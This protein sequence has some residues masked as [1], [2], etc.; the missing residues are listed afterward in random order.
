MF[1]LENNNEKIGKYLEHL[2]THQYP[3]R[4]AF[5]RA[6]ITATG[7]QPTNETLNNMSNR[8][9]QI[10]KGNKSIQ[11]YD[12]P[13]FTELL[14]IS[15]EQILS[16]GECSAPIASRITNY[17]IA[18]SKDPEAWEAYIHRSDKLILNS[19]EY[20]KTVLDYALDFGNYDFI[21]FLMDNQYIW[22]DS[23][24]DQD[25]IQT[26]GAG[27][28]IE[29]RHISS[30]DYGLEGKLRTEDE[31]RINL[32]TLAVDHEDIKMLNELRAR[33]SPQLYFKAN[34]LFGQHPDFDCCY[35]ERMVKH[36]SAASE[37]VIDYFTDSF[38][39]Q[40]RTRYSDGSNRIHTFMFPYITKL[41][42]LLIV[43]N[44]PFAE[45]ALKKALQHNK[46]TYK[47]LYKL[48]LS[49]KE[50][51]HFSSEYM[52]DMWIEICKQDYHFFDNGSIAMFYPIHLSN[53]SN[54]IIT[55]I[56]QVTRIPSSPILRHLAEELNASYLRIKNIAEHLEEI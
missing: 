9:M 17:S 4:R 8:L 43:A 38:E 24:K 18:C 15:C 34:Y 7:E 12:L 1:K 35:N 40:A 22:F 2:I 50:D 54:A 21:K 31:L 10:I 28:S 42:D 32:I 33:E 27:T 44:S 36:I 39:I 53:I 23:R 41:L 19:D 13:Y 46:T 26:F 25:Y 16:A 56:A 29:R 5:C 45:T 52:K 55:N 51:K 3:S 11:T 6:Y 30:I 14:G 20:C 37:A 48:I 49:V 47:K